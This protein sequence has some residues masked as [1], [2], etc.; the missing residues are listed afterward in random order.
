[1]LSANTQPMT[2]TTLHSKKTKKVFIVEDEGDMCLLL[3]IMLQEKTIELEHAKSIAAAQEYLKR[4]Q[5][6]I[7]ILDNKLPDGLGVDFVPYIKK[8]YPSVKIVMISGYTSEA[9]DLALEN[10]A[11]LFLEKPFTKQQLHDSVKKLLN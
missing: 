11:D 10:G 3:N 7:V 8:N 2:S 9:R 5:P 6:A 4:E 1:M